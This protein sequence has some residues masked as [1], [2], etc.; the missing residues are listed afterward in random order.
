MK[1]KSI[2]LI[3]ILQT[4]FFTAGFIPA[5]NIYSLELPWR[6][7]AVNISCIPKGM[8]SLTS[9]SS[10]KYPKATKIEQVKGRTNIL[11]HPLNTTKQTQGC[12]G[13]GKNLSLGTHNF[14]GSTHEATIRNSR[15]A[16]NMFLEY[17]EK[18]SIQ[19]IEIK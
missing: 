14:L 16:T 6:G 10:K 13:L 1:E 7:N 5:L 17:I 19:Y 8:Y 12:I 4:D 11:I 18:N 15:K 3:R 2:I 9:Y